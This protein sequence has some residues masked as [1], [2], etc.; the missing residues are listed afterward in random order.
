MCE[1][2]EKG[3]GKK[4]RK[5]FFTSSLRNPINNKQ[6]LFVVSKW[7]KAFCEDLHV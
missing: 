6:F 7:N 4:E 5:H 2:F 3:K 1:K